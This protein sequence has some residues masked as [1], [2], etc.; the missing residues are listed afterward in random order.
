MAPREGP[1][2]RQLGLG[3]REPLLVTKAGMPATG[4]HSAGGTGTGESQ[5]RPMGWVA[6]RR[7]RGARARQRPA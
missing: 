7:I 4:S 1:V 2:L 3:L 6:E 5:G